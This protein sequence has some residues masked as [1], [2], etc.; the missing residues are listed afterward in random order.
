MLCGVYLHPD[1]LEERRVSGGNFINSLVDDTYEWSPLSPWSPNPTRQLLYFLHASKSDIDPV[2]RRFVIQ[3]IMSDFS[4]SFFAKQAKAPDLLHVVALLRTN[5]FKVAKPTSIIY[6]DVLINALLFLSTLTGKPKVINAIYTH[7]DELLGYTPELGLGHRLIPFTL[8]C[9]PDLTTILPMIPTHKITKRDI[10]HKF[11]ESNRLTVTTVEIL[12]DIHLKLMPHR[13]NSREYFKVLQR[14]C[15]THPALVEFIAKVLIASWLGTY[16]TC[17]V[18][19][20]LDV[21]IRIYQLTKSLSEK[22]LK[23]FFTQETSIIVMYMFKEYFCEMFRRF[24]GF[25]QSLG[26]YNWDQYQSCA[27]DIGDTCVRVVGSIPYTFVG[28]PYVRMEINAKHDASRKWQKCSNINFNL[29]RI[30][31]IFDDIDYNNYPLSRAD[32]IYPP[33][34]EYNLP[35]PHSTLDEARMEVMRKCI[36]SLLDG[37]EGMNS[38]LSFEW[39]VYFGASRYWIQQLN[40]AV[41]DTSPT[42]RRELIRMRKIAKENY[43]IFYTFFTL[44][45]KANNYMDVP[46]DVDMMIAHTRAIAK[47]YDIK[48]GERIPE[49]CGGILVCDNCGDVKQSS[50]GNSKSQ[51]SGFGKT[52]ITGSWGL[53]CARQSA[54]AD[55]N[56]LYFFRHGKHSEASML[57][58]QRSTHTIGTAET[59]RRKFAK[60]VS[61]QILLRRCM[62]QP[63][64]KI[65]TLG[66]IAMYRGT[67]YVACFRC[68]TVAPLDMHRFYGSEILCANCIEVAA[69]TKEKEDK[70][71]AL[72][73]LSNRANMRCFYLFDDLRNVFRH[74]YFCTSHNSLSW[75]I[76]NNMVFLSRVLLEIKRHCGSTGPGGVYILPLG[77]YPVSVEQS[78]AILG[79]TGRVYVPDKDDE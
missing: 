21:R 68:P 70:Q 41:M 66:R 24:P 39:L 20:P 31:E 50:F 69:V 2:L 37:R 27:R 40:M 12:L 48:D 22:R 13:C 25:T 60:H 71:C 63:L 52:C 74:V 51:S 35:S 11:P 53:M 32:S 61:S 18:K 16:E 17:E 55:W 75:V 3:G 10:Q 28:F 36:D 5:K 1:E 8:M 64:R 79:Y 23:A 43:T 6:V 54:P 30:L 46:G 65:N 4:A 15:D 73:G 34:E 9:V 26:D 77:N 33:G 19:A 59:I 78:N 38:K 47:Y 42:L 7:V 56:D 67:I 29:V 72:C 57:S 58:K 49:V 14:A 76:P 44:L 45:S 62:Q